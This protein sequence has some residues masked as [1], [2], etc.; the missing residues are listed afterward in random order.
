MYKVN[1]NRIAPK[2]LD[3]SLS[4]LGGLP[5]TLSQHDILELVH[6]LGEACHV[7][8]QG[9]DVLHLDHGALRYFGLGGRAQGP[10]SLTFSVDPRWQREPWADMETQDGQFCLEY[11]TSEMFSRE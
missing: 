10:L 7:P 8:Q 3:P 9:W 11:F 2:C 6:G 4:L 1:S 5:L